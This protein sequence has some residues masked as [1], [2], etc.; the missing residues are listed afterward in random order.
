MNEIEKES[1]ENEFLSTH[2]SHETRAQDLL[3]LLPNA[4]Q[5][6]E[7]CKCYH[8]P[9]EI[10]RIEHKIETKKLIKKVSEK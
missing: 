9:K 8:L 3:K 4:L 5:I 10:K 2:P 6:R 1:S 7:N